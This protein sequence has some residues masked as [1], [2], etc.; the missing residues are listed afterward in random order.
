MCLLAPLFM[1]LLKRNGANVKHKNYILCDLMDNFTAISLYS[2]GLEIII[3]FIK[4]VNVT[5]SQMP[6]NHDIV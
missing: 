4:A 2:Y 3:M 1:T 5:K 6:R